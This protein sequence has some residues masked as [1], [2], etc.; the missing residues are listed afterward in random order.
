MVVEQPKF[1]RVEEPTLL[2]NQVDFGQNHMSGNP[3]PEDI[4]GAMAS[5]F[6]HNKKQ[7]KALRKR[8]KAEVEAAEKLTARGNRTQSETVLRRMAELNIKLSLTKRKK[9]KVK[10]LH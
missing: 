1:T 2:C 7:R 5:P 4:I 6:R 10:N 3:R 8:A 9:S